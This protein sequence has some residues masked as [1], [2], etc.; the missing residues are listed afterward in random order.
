MIGLL[1]S[2]FR[3]FQRVMIFDSNAHPTVSGKWPSKDLDAQFGTLDEQIQ[4][5]GFRGACAVGLFG[6]GAYTHR[7]FAVAC[8]KYPRM[9]PIAGC[10]ADPRANLDRELQE[11]VDLGYRGIK[12]HPRDPHVDLDDALLIKLLE[13]AT[14]HRMV[15]FLCTYAHGPISSYP[16]SDPFFQIVTLLKRVREARVVLVH[17]GDVRVLLFSELVR[18]NS[19]LLLDLSQTLMKYPGSSV[20]QDI[21]FL[22]RHFDRRICIGSD[23]PEYSLEQFKRRFE[24]LSA[25]APEEKIR[26]VAHRNIETFLGLPGRSG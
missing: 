8:S 22:I 4:S 3:V 25:G 6:M 18:F 7:D 10:T 17:G 2:R 12:I 1:R 9:I 20:D 5:Q 14:A 11:L 26:N 23:F 16:S 21:R 19:N 13:K 15:V 24:E